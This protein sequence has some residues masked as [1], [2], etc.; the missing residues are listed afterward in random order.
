MFFFI[1]RNFSSNKYS[2]I[3]QG[4]YIYIYIYIYSWSWLTLK[5]VV[6]EHMVLKLNFTINNT[7]N[8][9]DVGCCGAINTLRFRH[10]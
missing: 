7:L 6:S 1:K 8:L 5:N 3:V 2:S 9:S 4:I 10:L